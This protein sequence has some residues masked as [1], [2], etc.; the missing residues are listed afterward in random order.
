MIKI[1]LQRH[2]ARHSPFYRMVV[3]PSTTRRDGKFI[4]V[5][6]TYHPQAHLRSEELNLKMERIDH[7]LGVGAQPTDTARSLIRQSRLSPEQWLEKSEREASNRLKRA[8]KGNV[9]PA[10]EEAKLEE[11]SEESAPVKEEKTEAK[12]PAEADTKAE[13]KA[14]ETK[15]EESAPVKEE[16]TEAKAPAEAD[17][18][19]EEKAPETKSEEPASI[20]E[21][22]KIE[23]KG[24]AKEEEN[25]KEKPAVDEKSKEVAGKDEPKAKKSEE[26]SKEA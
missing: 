20:K 13:E 18:K 15:S 14:P 26:D 24:S 9:A 21:K 17:T 3:T 22:G 5:L 4:E 1:R 8:Q 2:G 23:D 19:V 6:G 10:M 16:K 11:K 12:A 7:W 25:L